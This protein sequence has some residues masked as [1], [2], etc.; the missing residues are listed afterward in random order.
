MSDVKI[1]TFCTETSIGSILQSFGL[2]KALSTLGIESS[3][4]VEPKK[5]N[6]KKKVSI[7]QLAR[8]MMRSL[9][10]RKIE[11]AYSKRKAFINSNLDIKY[12]DDSIASA[13]NSESIY[14]A[15]SDQIWNPGRIVPLFFLDFVKKG[16]CISYAASMGNTELSDE[17][18]EFYSQ[19]LRGFDFISVREQECFDALAPLTD[20]DISVNIDPTFLMS[21]DDWR[22]YE[23][24][25]K[26]ANKYILLY[27]L[28][29]NN[30][31]KSL[32]QQLKKNTGLPV[33]AICHDVSRVYADKYLYDVGVE[34]FLWLFDNA[35]YIVTSSFHGVAFSTIFNK[36][37]SAIINPSSPSRIENLLN[38][39]SVPKAKI[40]ELDKFN[41]DYAKT[42]NKIKHEKEK[43]MEYLRKTVIE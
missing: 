12:Y 17:N 10:N 2:N 13:D 38:T 42:N 8:N 29:W 41:F 16:K 36:K 43:S 39:L 20:K 21:A 26:T 14:I 32:I 27:M 31:C 30:D 11:C 6:I 7:K 4:I 3:I 34:E 18:K 33:Y 23:K 25:Y 5:Q 1:V 22:I 9:V 40:N 19:K 28:Y 35:E 37:F 24:P 15:G